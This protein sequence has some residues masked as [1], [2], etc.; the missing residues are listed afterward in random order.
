MLL[1][2][3]FVV[4]L[5]VVS[6][7]GVC[8]LVSGVGVSCLGRWF[9]WCFCGGCFCGGVV[10]GG[11]VVGAGGAVVTMG[12]VDVRGGPFWCW[13]CSCWRFYS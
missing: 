4:I 5:I 13:P 10:V 3:L 6:G 2:L 7:V 12:A 1:L 9:C 8:W 11:V